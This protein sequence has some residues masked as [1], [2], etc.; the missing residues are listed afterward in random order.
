MDKPNDRVEL[1]RENC[2]T[3]NHIVEVAAFVCGKDLVVV[4][5][6]GTRYHVGAVALAIPRPSL[7]DPNQVSASA[8]VLCV[9]GHKE[10]ELARNAAL[11]IAA[12]LNRTVT[13]IAGIH[14]DDAKPE[15]LS[16]L[17]ENCKCVIRSLIDHF[18]S[19]RTLISFDDFS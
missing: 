12:A 6:G 13:V 9:T 18:K 4:I 1:F 19:I 14:I 16:D 17:L 15:D 11:Q 3:G 8:S 5:E 7:A 2:G 10:D